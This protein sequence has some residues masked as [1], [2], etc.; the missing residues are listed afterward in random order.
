MVIC[1]ALCEAAAMIGVFLFSG[2]VPAWRVKSSNGR[3]P[4]RSM[5][6]QGAR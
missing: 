5:A 6:E 3:Y 1:E 2:T 4:G